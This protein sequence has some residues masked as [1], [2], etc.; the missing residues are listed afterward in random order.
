[1]SVLGGSRPYSMETHT[2]LMGLLYS[3]TGLQLVGPWQEGVQY[4]LDIG[5]KQDVII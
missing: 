2:F 4:Y 5:T 1:M 3:E